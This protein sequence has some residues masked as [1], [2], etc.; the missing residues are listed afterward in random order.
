MDRVLRFDSDAIEM[1][2]GAVFPVRQRDRTKLFGEFTQYQFRTMR[3][4][5]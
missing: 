3:N 2:D 1:S 4:E 5:V